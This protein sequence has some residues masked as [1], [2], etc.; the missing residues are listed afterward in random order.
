M[1]TKREEEEKE[2]EKEEEETPPPR[3]SSCTSSSSS[4][5][6]EKEVRDFIIFLSFLSLVVLLF[7]FRN[8]SKISFFLSREERASFLT[9]AGFPFFGSFSL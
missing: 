7:S 4:S 6:S 1:T 2:K 5:S 9:R 8:G 3:S